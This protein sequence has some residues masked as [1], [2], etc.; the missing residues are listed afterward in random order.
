MLLKDIY[1][2]KHIHFSAGK[3]TWQNSLRECCKPL[4]ETGVVDSGYAEELI[5]CV[6]K[7]GPYIVILPGV[8]LPHSTENAKGCHGTAIAFMKSDTPISFE[9]GNPDKDAVIFFTLASTNPDEH[10][11]NMQQ[12]YS[13]LTNEEAL[14]AL[15]RVEKAEDLLEIDKMLG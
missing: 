9:D 5:A 4:V 13:V 8:C 10:M 1:D 3:M 11:L 6:E 12:L 15:K 2:K 14:E 7:H